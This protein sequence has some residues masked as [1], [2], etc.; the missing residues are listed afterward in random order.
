MPARITVCYPDLPAKESLLFEHS[1]YRVGRDNQC[2]VRLNHP[3]VSR[4]HATLVA[5]QDAWQL[6]DKLSV[7]GLKVNG[8]VVSDSA[9]STNDIITVGEL[10]CL[11]ELKS[12][13]QLNAINAH[14]QWRLEQ[15]RQSYS[16]LAERSLLDALDEQLYSLLNLTGTQRGLVMLGNSVE[17]LTVC[18]AKGMSDHDFQAQS[19]QGSVG[20]MY[21]ALEQGSPLLAMDTQL[22]SGLAARESIQRKK[23][24]ALACIP[25]LSENNLIGVVYTDSHE[26]NK[27]LT[28]LDVEILNLISTQI[29]TNSEAIVLQNQISAILNNMPDD[30]FAN[31]QILKK[32]LSSAVH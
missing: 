22:D 24:A 5:K 15:S 31:Q 28:E 12:E 32:Q 14:D 29:R 30:I 2:D 19:F 4:Q 23:I 7:N 3:S 27:V 9:L 1:Q 16:E 17:T 8:Q 6:H 25:L 10:D 21:R 11:F 26:A 13:T 18:A 20:A